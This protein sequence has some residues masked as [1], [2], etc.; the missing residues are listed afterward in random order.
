MLMMLGLGCC[1]AKTRPTKM[2]GLA[3]AVLPKGVQQLMLMTLGLARG[4]AARKKHLFFSL[5]SFDPC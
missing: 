2:L 5:F 1:S 3:A 4:N